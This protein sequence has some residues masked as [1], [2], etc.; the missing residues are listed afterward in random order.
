MNKMIILALAFIP[1]AAHAELVAANRTLPRGEE[2]PAYI[3]LVYRSPVG[4]LEFLKRGDSHSVFLRNVKGSLTELTTINGPVACDAWFI[5]DKSES[6]PKGCEF[7]FYSK[8]DGSR[9]NVRSEEMNESSLFQ[10]VSGSVRERGKHV[11]L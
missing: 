4:D 7:E 3:E 5:S 1:L 10:A 8:E 11:A 6:L 9:L 2:K